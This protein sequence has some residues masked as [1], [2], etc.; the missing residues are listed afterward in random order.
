MISEEYVFNRTVKVFTERPRHLYEMFKETVQKCPSREALVMNNKRLTYSEMDIQVNLLASNLYYQFNLKRGDRIALFLGNSIE[1]ALFV[2]ACAKIGAILVPLN[3]RSGEEEILYRINHSG[4]K[5]VVTD[6]EFVTKIESIRNSKE[7]ETPAVETFILTGEGNFDN[8]GRG[9]VPF[10]SLTKKKHVTNP[11]PDKVFDVAPFAIMYTSGTTGLPKG[12]VLSHIGIIHS[13][14]SYELTMKT[15]E[16]TRTLIAIPLFH[17]TGLIGQLIHMVSV[18]GTSVLIK[19]YKTDT[20]LK[21]IEAEKIT[22]LFNVPTI[23]VMMMSHPQ[24]HNYSLESI[25]TIAY[26]GAPMATDTIQKLRIFIPNINLHNAYGATETSSPTT[27]S[28]IVYSDSK[29]ASVGLPVP[30]AEIKIVNKDFEEVKV[31]QIGEL[32][33]KGPMVIKGYWEN[34][35]ANHNSFYNGYWISGDI[36]RKDE[37]GFIYIMDRKKDVIN[38]GGE[39]IY[40]VEVESVLY[41]H[42]CVLEVAIVGVPDS[43]FGEQVVAFVVKREQRQIT[44]EE[45]KNYVTQKLADYKAPKDVMFVDNLPRNEGGK[46]LKKELVNKYID[47]KKK[48]TQL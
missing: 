29:L 2:F 47:L 22:F 17:V 39:K 37:D 43:V 26:G 48:S 7:H 9:Y 45:I 11:I 4:S 16:Q 19:R 10:S 3:T 42:P 33:I 32:L 40:S 46:I 5:V 44:M 31:N 20:F 30:V 23:Y 6:N 18:G 21:T 28:P 25:K 24:I 35:K 27:I 38:R 1:F 14:M 41:T 15:S 36:G 13:A 34:E 12:A 8:S